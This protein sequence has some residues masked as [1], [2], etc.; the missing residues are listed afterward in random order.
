VADNLDLERTRNVANKADMMD[1]SAGSDERRR[2]SQEGIAGA[3]AV[4]QFFANAGMV[5]TIPPRS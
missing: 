2:H 1:R 4:D 3:Y 5:C